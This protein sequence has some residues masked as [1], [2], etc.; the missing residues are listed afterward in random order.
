VGLLVGQ[1]LR[2]QACL[3]DGGTSSITMNFM[4]MAY[5]YTVLSQAA[6]PICCHNAASKTT[7]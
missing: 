2:H 4:H 7:C 3:Q 6:W 1:G 5:R